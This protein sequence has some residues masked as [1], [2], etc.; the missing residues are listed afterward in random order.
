MITCVLAVDK[1]RDLCLEGTMT[2]PLLWYEAVSSDLF[3]TVR[4]EITADRW[5]LPGTEFGTV[6]SSTPT[7][8]CA[9]VSCTDNFTLPYR[10]WNNILES[11]FEFLETCSGVVEYKV[12]M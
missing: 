1:L 12:A 8:P 11:W 7:P 4:T 10:Y 2:D 5:P 6:Y 9:F 3:T